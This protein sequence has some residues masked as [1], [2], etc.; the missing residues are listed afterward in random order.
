[1]LILTDAAHDALVAAAGR[2]R[3][4]IA[5]VRVAV[6]EPDC[7]APR[8]ALV[9]A[10]TV[11]L[12]DVVVESGR[13][14]LLI[15][16]DSAPQLNG[17]TIDFLAPDPSADDPSRRTGGFTFETGRGDACQFCALSKRAA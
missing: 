2:S 17:T 5:G 3:R 1:M 8:Y 6:I 11:D 7:R 9:L 12:D 14:R 4:P 16:R 10:S 15:D 13:I